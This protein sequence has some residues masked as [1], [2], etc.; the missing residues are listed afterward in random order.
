VEKKREEFGVLV[1]QADLEE[2]LAKLEVLT[3]THCNTLRY[4]A[5]HCIT[6]QH[7]VASCNTL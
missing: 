4:N 7:T 6:M 5:A 3:A 2:K 1:F